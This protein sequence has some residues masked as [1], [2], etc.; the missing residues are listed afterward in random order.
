M[1]RARGAQMAPLRSLLLA[2]EGHLLWLLLE[3]PHWPL[4]MVLAT[5]RGREDVVWCATLAPN[6]PAPRTMPVTMG[7]RR[8]RQS[9][10]V[11][12]R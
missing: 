11:S 10:T 6:R 2:M 3:P 4:V 1:E 7:V 9:P 8:L 12:S 5:M